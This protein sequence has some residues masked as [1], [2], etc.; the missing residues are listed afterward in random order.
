M[1]HW[2]F[3]SLKTGTKNFNWQKATQATCWVFAE[4][5][6]VDFDSVAETHKK[7]R[8]TSGEEYENVL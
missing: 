8:P 1:K 5:Q 6:E 7:Q 4:R 2:K 3:I